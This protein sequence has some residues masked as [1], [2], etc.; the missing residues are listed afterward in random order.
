MVIATVVVVSV[1]ATIVAVVI[2]SI[3]VIVA[4]IG[5]AVTVI[6]SIRSTVR[7]SKRW[8]PFRSSL[9]LLLVF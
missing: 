2:T 4:M 1:I 9:L 3:T 7:L 5:P 6:T 8:P